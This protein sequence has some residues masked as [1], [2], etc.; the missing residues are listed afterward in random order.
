ML[1]RWYQLNGNFERCGGPYTTAQIQKMLE[2]GKLKK[3]TPMESEDGRGT[4][5]DCVFTLNYSDNVD[6]G[7]QYL[8][9]KQR[10]YLRFLGYNGS[11]Y[12]SQDD[13]SYAI[14]R[15]K[16]LNPRGVAGPDYDELVAQE[17]RKG[18]NFFLEADAYVKKRG[19]DSLPKWLSPPRKKSGLLW[20]VSLPFR[21]LYHISCIIL[22]LFGLAGKG[23]VIAGQK[24]AELAKETASK[25][26][27]FEKENKLIQGTAATIFEKA[28]QGAKAGASVLADSLCIEGEQPMRTWT[29]TDGNHKIEAQLVAVSETAV[30]LQKAD[31]SLIDVQKSQLC[32]EDHL[33]IKGK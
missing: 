16:S 27:E 11:F 20:L 17:T 5:A 10:A 28:K 1:D 29:S 22:K 18:D 15:L 6:Y 4:T 31:G 23:A 12:I 33:A 9:H 7:Y 24:G 21:L 3:S 14:Q 26:V 30:R 32:P 8:T 19:Y 13:C 2:S 25:A